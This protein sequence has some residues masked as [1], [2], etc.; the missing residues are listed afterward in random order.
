[1]QTGNGMFHPALSN[2]GSCHM[3]NRGME[4]FMHC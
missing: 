4:E 2:G 1:M 3:G